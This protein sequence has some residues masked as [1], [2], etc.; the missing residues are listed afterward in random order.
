MIGNILERINTK[1]VA[2]RDIS[3]VPSNNLT[4]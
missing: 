1:L 3:W 2:V 4:D